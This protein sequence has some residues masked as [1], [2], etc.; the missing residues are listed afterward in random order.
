MPAVITGRSAF[1]TRLYRYSGSTWDAIPGLKSISGPR[2]SSADI[3]ITNHDSPNGWNEYVGGLREG[4]TVTL[5]GNFISENA[6]QKLVMTDFENATVL[7]WK[8]VSAGTTGTT[9]TFEAKVQEYGP[10]SPFDNA[11][12]WSFTLKLAGQVTRA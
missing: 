5:S 10:D 6:I 3:N 9:W 11:A 7:Q 8:M 12:S 1:G 2:Q 4:G